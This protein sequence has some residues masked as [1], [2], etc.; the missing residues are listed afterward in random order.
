MSQLK[1]KFKW[2]KSLYVRT[3]PAGTSVQNLVYT[4]FGSEIDE[5]VSFK[6]MKASSW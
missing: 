4:E 1:K 5:W 6:T 2:I 3:F